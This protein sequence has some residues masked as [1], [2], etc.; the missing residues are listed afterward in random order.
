[1]TAA[2]EHSATRYAQTLLHDLEL[3]SFAVRLE[4]EHPALGWARSGLMQLTGLP[5]GPP[6]LCPAA[7]TACADGALAALRSLAAVNLELRGSQLLAERAAI[8]GYQRQGEIS[9]GGSCRL[10]KLADG[11]LALNLARPEDWEL[12][13]AWLESAAIA[14]W[15]A[16]QAQLHEREQQPLLQR[17][18]ELG[19]AL[20][21]VQE[22][23]TA[24]SW[25][26]KSGLSRKLQRHRAPRVL[27]LAAL[28]AGPLCGHLLHLCGVEVIKLE[29]PSRPDGARQGPAAFFDL[30]N[31]GKHSVAL[32]FQQPAARH[33]LREL[34]RNVDIV[35]EGSRPRA[36]RQLGI[37]AEEILQEQPGLS[38]VS[39]TGHG[40]EHNWI[41]YGDDAAVAGGLTQ[42]QQEVSGELM[43]VGDAL[44]DPLT[45]LHAALAAYAG[46]L[47]GGGLYAL[48]L[49]QVV[50]HILAFE[51]PTD[52]AARRQRYGEWQ[53]WLRNAGQPALPPT[54]R[55][56]LFK[57]RALGADTGKF[58]S[59]TN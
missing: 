16:L 19:L 55:E 39:I 47:N 51:R 32:D 59:R 38:W 6:Q 9:A 53:Q 56:P 43:F 3:P 54:A 27:E 36:L 57:A 1:M 23:F 5:D 8:F 37:V 2:V 34:I 11:A 35:V 26:Q 7:I 21:A 14:D 33:C 58:L 40:R 46:Y 28:W 41:A 18:R 12:L 20:S 44:A 13:P 52:L 17:G 49:S 10:L 25:F 22:P 48:A 30:L 31:A 50:A 24:N 29:S 45:G 42:A 15:P 4:P